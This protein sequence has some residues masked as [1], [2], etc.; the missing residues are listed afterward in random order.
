MQSHFRI[1]YTLASTRSSTLH[2]KL[3]SATIGP[4]YLSRLRFPLTSRV[5]TGL[6]HLSLVLHA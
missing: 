6:S 3:L 1:S 5:S 4:I 2:C